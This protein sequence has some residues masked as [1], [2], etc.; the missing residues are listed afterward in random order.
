MFKLKLERWQ[1]QYLRDIFLQ[2]S[3]TSINDMDALYIWYCADVS[4]R[5]T[6]RLKRGSKSFTITFARYESILLHEMAELKIRHLSIYPTHIIEKRFLSHLLE[7][8]GNVKKI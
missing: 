1:L 2:Y 4:T 8:T 7:L 5:F 3:Q 6:K